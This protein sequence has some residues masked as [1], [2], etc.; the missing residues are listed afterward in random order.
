MDLELFDKLTITKMNV[1]T[2]ARVVY[3]R[4]ERIKYLYA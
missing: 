1:R 3:K 2:N 4:T